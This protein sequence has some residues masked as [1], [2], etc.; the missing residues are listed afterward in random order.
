MAEQGFKPRASLEIVL[1]NITLYCLLF[2]IKTVISIERA[3]TER[4]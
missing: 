3:R 2:L 1:L 4:K